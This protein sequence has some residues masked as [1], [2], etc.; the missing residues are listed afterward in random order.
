MRLVSSPRLDVPFAVAVCVGPQP[1]EVDR[2]LDLADSLC[3]YER[4][5]GWLVMVDDAEVP[6]S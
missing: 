3:A 6:R 2:L 1:V 5:P 4:G